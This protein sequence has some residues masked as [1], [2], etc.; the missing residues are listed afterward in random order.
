VVPEPRRLIELARIGGTSIEWVLTGH[1]WENGSEEQERLS[2]DLLRTACILREINSEGRA[3]V[4]EALRI[5]RDAVGAL[6]TADAAPLPD[7]DALRDHSPG[8]LR[9]LEAATRIQRA[10]LRRI[11]EEADRRLGRSA[12]FVSSTAPGDKPDEREQSSRADRS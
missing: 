1:H 2:S 6:E 10:V 3:T 9:L 11:T 5:V 8:T 12:H 4:N 7:L